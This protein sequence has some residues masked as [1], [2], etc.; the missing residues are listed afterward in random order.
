MSD[1]T[2]T[3][4]SLSEAWGENR[5]PIIALAFCFVLSHVL[6]MFIVPAFEEAEVQAFEDPE[7][8]VNSFVYIGII[9][10]F[11]AL[12]LWIAKN[13]LDYILQAIFLSSIGITFIYVFYP[14]FYTYGIE[15][16]AGYI[17]AAGLAIQLT[18]LLMTYP[19][20]YVIDIAGIILAAGVAAI[21][22]LSFGLLPALLL[23]VGLAIYDA[24]AVYRT[25]HMVDLAA[26]HA[27][28]NACTHAFD[29]WLH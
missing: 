5:V 27:S 15:D 14:F 25:G 29:L 4:Q 19:E 26:S 10:V 8:P 7:D 16:T 18:F 2:K 6:A 21:F 20:W 1:S 11:T 17:G 13:G 22:G 3:E 9:L 23:L 24:W 12:V 28:I